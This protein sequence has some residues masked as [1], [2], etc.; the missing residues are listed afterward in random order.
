M[1]ESIKTETSQR[2]LWGTVVRF[3]RPYPYSK[4]VVIVKFDDG[5]EAEFWASRFPTMKFKERMRVKCMV[6][7]TVETTFSNCVEGIV[8]S[9]EDEAAIAS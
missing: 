2:E 4:G 6:Q 9:I 5:T 8:E 1:R 7:R 3:C